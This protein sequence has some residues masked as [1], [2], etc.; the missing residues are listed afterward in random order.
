VH[1]IMVPRVDIV[2]VDR[3]APWS[4]VVDRVRS[5]EHSRLPVFTDSVDNVVGVMY[6]KDLLASIVTDESP[7]G[8]WSTLVRP[9]VFI[10]GAKKADLQLRDFQASATHMAI[11][12]D[13]FGG[14]AG[15]VTIE[16]VLEEIVGDIRDE[17]DVE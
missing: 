17:Y 10:P 13:E 9:A 4:E 6:A 11:V 16:D 8:G 14:T 15:L 1:E 3:D 12:V 2:A 7:A 5:S